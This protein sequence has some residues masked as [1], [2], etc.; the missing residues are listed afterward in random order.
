MPLLAPPEEK[1]RFHMALAVQRTPLPSTH[2][3]LWVLIGRAE[4]TPVKA[5]VNTQATTNATTTAK[6]LLPDGVRVV[7]REGG[8]LEY[9]LNLS[10]LYRAGI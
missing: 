6:G 2:E 8:E 4:A 7:G 5:P 10:L 9:T 3:A 1:L